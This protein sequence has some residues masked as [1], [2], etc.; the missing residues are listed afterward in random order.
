M[1]EQMNDH[2]RQMKQSYLRRL[3]HI[4][5]KIFDYQ[6]Q[7]EEMEDDLNNEPCCTGDEDFLDWCASLSAEV[8]DAA[9]NL[10]DISC[11]LEEIV[12]DNEEDKKD[13]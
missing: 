4:Q 13:D 3:K 9:S 7:L 6:M 5:E 1:R 11:N 10:S 2:V 12:G 8:A